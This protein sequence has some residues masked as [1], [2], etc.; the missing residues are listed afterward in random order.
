MSGYS[1]IIHY[2]TSILCGNK[3]PMEISQ[4]LSKNPKSLNAYVFVFVRKECKFSHNIQTQHNYP[5][6]WECTLHDLNEDD[7]FLLLLQNDPN[8]LPEKNEICLHFTRR[9]CKF[10]DQCVLVHFNLTYKWEVNDGKGWRDLRNMEEIETSLGFSP[11]SR[12]WIWYYKG[13]HENWIE[14]GQ[15][16][17]K[18]HVMSDVDLEKAFQ[19]DIFDC[20]IFTD[21]YHRN[22]KHNT[23]RRVRW[24]PRFMSINE[25]EAKAAQ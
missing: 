18:Q 7:L 6:Q 15:P 23:K 11:D 1:R 14:Y 16:G 17:D 2:A 10:Q 9:K 5:L 19:E 12:P 25:V 13:D 4:L 8:L 22:P 24:R 20:S 3:G 21:M